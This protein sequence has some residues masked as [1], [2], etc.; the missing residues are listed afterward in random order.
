LFHPKLAPLKEKA[1]RNK[2][3]TGTIK[4]KEENGA[5]K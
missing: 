4:I 2:D 5:K 3:I 1:A